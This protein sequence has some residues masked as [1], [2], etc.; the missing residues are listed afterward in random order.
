M[1]QQEHQE[2]EI[3]IIEIIQYLLRYWY[4]FAISVV[5]FCLAGFL[6]VKKLT[7]LYE[8][9]ASVII[10]QEKTAPEEMLLLQDIGLNGGTNNI[11]NE[12]GTL[13]SVDFITK[14]VTSL[15]LYTSYRNEKRYGL[16]YAPDLY[17]SSPYYVRWENIEPDKIP[18]SINFHIRKDKSTTLIES[19]YYKDGEKYSDKTTLTILPGYINLS[20]GKFYIEPTKYLTDKQAIIIATIQNPYELARNI[21]SNLNIATSTK[22]SSQLNLILKSENREK[23]T[24]FLA[25]LINEYNKDAIKDKNMIS[26]NTAVFIEERLKEIASELGQVE[27]QV[28][29]FRRENKIADIPTQVESYLKQTDDFNTQRLEIETQMNLLGYIKEFISNQDNKSKLIPNLGIKDAGLNSVI[30]RYNEMLIEKNRIE[31]SSSENNPVLIQMNSQTKNLLHNIQSSL[32]N[33]INASTIALRDLERENT[34]NS[35]LIKRLPTVDREYTEILRQQEVKSNLFIYLLQKREET[36]LT[37]AAVAPKAKIIEQPRGGSNPVEPR[38]SMVMLAFLVVS[39]VLPAGLLY[40]KSMFYTKIEGMGDL[41]KLKEV[42]TVGDIAIVKEF[43][44]QNNRIVVQANNTSPV[45]E[46]FRTL[47]NNLMFMTSEENQRVILVTSTI[48]KEGK[49]FIAANLAK[50]LSL[51][52]KKVVLVGADIRNPQISNTLGIEKSKKG[53]TSYLAGIIDNPSEIIEPIGDNFDAIQTGP[54]PP[55]PNELLAKPRVGELIDLLKDIYDYI[56]IDSA[57][58]GLVSDT[59]IISKYADASIFVIRENFSEKD[60]ISFINSI[61]REKRLHN[62]AVVLNQTSNSG[63]SGNYKY[64]YK[65]SYSY[66]YRYKYGYKA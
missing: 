24:D 38:K 52:D 57:P 54:I 11:D 50:S 51:I 44:N 34:T 56:I 26:F 31:N 48:S 39:V 18:V 6:Y 59:F 55:N 29:S 30:K 60:T 3:D 63:K 65:Y 10:K 41:S 4:I 53:L 12:I 36:N 37:Q 49:T 61:H 16:F 62:I 8:I 19:E 27:N 40:L 7:P 23:G 28:E 14:V 33:E 21:L 35:N 22:Q 1:N 42:S 32:N 20:I 45:N 58:V 25:A 47:R 9:S 64:G 13:K 43:E 5:I 46:M 15:E 17:K 66:S 2:Q